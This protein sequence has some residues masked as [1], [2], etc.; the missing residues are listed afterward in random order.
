LR[1]SCL[2]VAAS[3][4]LVSFLSLVRVPGPVGDPAT[5]RN[6]GRANERRSKQ[7]ALDRLLSVGPARPRRLGGGEPSRGEDPL[8]TARAA[9]WLATFPPH[10]GLNSGRRKIQP[11]RDLAGEAREDS[12]SIS[13][14]MPFSS[15]AWR[16]AL[17]AEIAPGHPGRWGGASAEPRPRSD[18]AE[19]VG[20]GAPAT[21]TAAAASM[22]PARARAISHMPLSEPS[23]GRGARCG[24]GQPCS[25]EIDK[26]HAAISA[27]R[28]NSH[29]LRS[30]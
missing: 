17:A 23:T 19:G 28:P 5:R 18:V 13:D 25:H 27:F 22:R 20:E 30:G 21:T 14:W 8:A 4:V 9:A 10:A 11:P 24:R 3:S 2:D 26:L 16:A 1:S 15:S 12:T 29:A 6:G 7:G